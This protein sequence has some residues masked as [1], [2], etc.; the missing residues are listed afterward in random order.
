MWEKLSVPFVNW[1]LEF[2]SE[3]TVLKDNSHSEK[4]MDFPIVSITLK[5]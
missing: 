5:Y 4:H 2:C 3:E 1:E